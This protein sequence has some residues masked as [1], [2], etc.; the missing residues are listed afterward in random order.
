MDVFEAVCDT[1]DKEFLLF[2]VLLL[3]L[4]LFVVV[5]LLPLVL[6][7]KFALQGLSLSSNLTLVGIVEI[8]MA[9]KASAT[10]W[11]VGLVCLH[12]SSSDFG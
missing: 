8:G 6:F 11:W 10:S 2:V 4:V 12:P 7:L 9:T 5:L 3:V 1:L